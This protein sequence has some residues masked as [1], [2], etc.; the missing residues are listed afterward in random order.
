MARRAKTDREA[1]AADKTLTS[2]LG[3]SL[4]Q[5]AERIADK[6]AE[7][8]AS[9]VADKLADTFV[10]NITSD[11]FDKIASRVADKI[12]AK[13]QDQPAEQSPGEISDKTE[14]SSPAGQLSTEAPHEV[15]DEP[16]DV[17]TEAVIWVAA[18][19]PD[20][21]AEQD[22]ET[23]D[24]VESEPAAAEQAPEETA[25]K[26]EAEPQAPLAELPVPVRP[27][28]GP[29]I[30]AAGGK[31]RSPE[32]ED[33]PPQKRARTADDV[34]PRRNPKRAA[35]EAAEHV[36]RDGVALP[37]DLL[38]EALRPLS[39]EEIEAWEGWV[40]LES[41]PAFFNFIVKKLGVKGVTI[42]E[43]LSL[44]SWSMGLLPKPVFGL[45]FLF[46]YTP[47]LDD[48]EDDSDDDAPVWFAN[49]TT[50]NSCASVALLNIIM[51]TEQVELCEQ[52]QVFKE[53]TKDLSSPLRGRRIGAN[54][55]IR[56][57]HNSFVRRI[58]MLEADLCLSNEVDSAKPRRSK[59]SVAPKKGRKQGP[60]ASEEFGFHF[61]AYVPANGF[62][63]ELDGMRA[64][65]RNVGPLNPEDWTEVATPRIQQR[66]QEYGNSANGFSL[67][68]MC[69]SP[70]D[71]LRSAIA[72]HASAID[73]L[74]SRF[75]DDA[76]FARLISAD[77]G[78]LGVIDNDTA[79]GEFGLQQPDVADAEVP[80]FV[81]ELM[82]RPDMDA[83]QAH[84]LYE[85]LVAGTKFAMAKYREETIAVSQ[86]EERVRG[87]QKDYTPALHCWMT[88]LANKG[89]LEDV[90]RM[91]Q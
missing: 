8:L 83:Q 30:F 44:E 54:G 53:S 56:A 74:R 4:E 16:H 47:Q 24:K 34:T 80:K 59:K 32:T 58:D 89:V 77:E 88:K 29:A 70:L 14:P 42:K 50:P 76:A 39:A 49:Q 35:N 3:Q 71:A 48:E 69:Q 20:L 62:V 1:A 36:A 81:A 28:D 90:I 13:T 5:V 7:K 26:V 66:I 37:D 22:L 2:A 31:R 21:L 78:L 79:L 64:N 23:A 60:A 11:V 72:S 75:Q 18:A 10:A 40:E 38:M 84:G 45:V 41:E 87:R 9:V 68:A 19:S 12:E 67:I 86:E 6:V 33:A 63:W 52:L 51:N 73:R 55:F 17:S 65:P 61:I 85:K 25:P 46:Q 57:A 43:L 91:S 27:D 82:S 15:E